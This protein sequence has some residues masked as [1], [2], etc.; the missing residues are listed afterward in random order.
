MPMS[1]TP[2]AAS[3][4]RFPPSFKSSATRMSEK[5]QID[6]R[7]CET[8]GRTCVK[9]GVYTVNY[10]PGT[11]K[12]TTFSKPGKAEREITNPVGLFETIL[13]SEYT[14]INSGDAKAIAQEY[15]NKFNPP[16]PAKRGG[17]AGPAIQPPPT[18]SPAIAVPVDT[19]DHNGESYNV[20]ENGD[21]LKKGEACFVVSKR[22]ANLPSL[23]VNEEGTSV[24]KKFNNSDKRNI[25]GNTFSLHIGRFTMV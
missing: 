13:K 16:L 18:M 22:D 20:Y 10:D 8:N 1:T 23:R 11:D 12:F 25:N 14:G 4:G 9:I 2:S 15:V 5:A 17:G 19:I 21:H 7:T 24:R 3:G 6:L